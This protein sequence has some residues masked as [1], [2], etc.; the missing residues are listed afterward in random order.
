MSD[1]T[2]YS[3]NELSLIFANDEF[4]YNQFFKCVRLESLKEL[5]AICEENFIFTDEQFES[6]ESDFNTELNND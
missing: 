2:N 6:L 5:K 3:E 4:F 1:L